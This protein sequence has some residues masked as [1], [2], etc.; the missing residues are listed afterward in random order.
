MVAG[1]FV[2]QLRDRTDAA[3]QEL[4]D[5]FYARIYRYLARFVDDPQTAADLT[6]DTFLKV[7]LALPRLPDDTN[8]SAWLFQIATNVAR[9]HYRRKRLIR[10][11]PLEHWNTPQPSGEDQVIQR[12]Q[13]DRALNA[14]SIEYKT[15]LLLH[16]WAGLTC[17]EIGET[18]GKTAS[19]VKMLLMRARR[20]FR[21]AYEA[22]GDETSPEEW[23]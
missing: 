12:D 16:V 17:A 21:A 1:Q 19:S 20:Q 7:Y 14:L 9:S 2:R 10:W 23:L 11:L 3:I 8:V 18:I 22:S 6:Q 5:Q 4:F 13:V 15:C